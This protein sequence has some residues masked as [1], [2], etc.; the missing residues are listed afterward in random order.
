MNEWQPRR[1]VL[2]IDVIGE[3]AGDDFFACYEMARALQEV[4]K[5]RR[6]EQGL[7][8]QFEQQAFQYADLKVTVK[9][10][11]WNESGG[12]IYRLLGAIKGRLMWWFR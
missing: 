8:P 5:S 10:L 2:R 9:S 12:W 11:W 1:T 3:T 6:I 4:A 7:Y